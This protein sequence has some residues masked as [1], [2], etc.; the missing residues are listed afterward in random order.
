MDKKP[1]KTLVI[2]T[3]Q[4][5]IDV[6]KECMFTGFMW[7]GLNHGQREDEIKKMKCFKEAIRLIRK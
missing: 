2:K 6:I 5:E 3:L 1:N 7:N 4:R